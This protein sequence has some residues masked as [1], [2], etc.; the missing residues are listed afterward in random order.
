[1]AS[2]DMPSNEFYVVFD[3]DHKIESGWAYRSDANDRVKELHEVEPCRVLTR[4]HTIIL[5]GNPAD[6]SLWR[7]PEIK[8]KKP[9]SPGKGLKI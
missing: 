1:M 3:K 4:M 5:C 6:D 9:A 2:I 8:R 7:N